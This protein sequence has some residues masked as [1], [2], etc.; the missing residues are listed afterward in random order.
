MLNRETE[1]IYRMYLQPI[2]H[3][4]KPIN[5]GLCHK[6]FIVFLRSPELSISKSYAFSLLLNHPQYVDIFPM[7]SYSHTFIQ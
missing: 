6:V 3:T 4:K 2:T 5:S 7:A 1:C